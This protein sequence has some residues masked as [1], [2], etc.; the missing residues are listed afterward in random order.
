MEFCLDLS[1]ISSDCLTVEILEDHQIFEVINVDLFNHIV[2][3]YYELS[4]EEYTFCSYNPVLVY[5]L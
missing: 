4:F 3:K 2:D 1:R 5:T